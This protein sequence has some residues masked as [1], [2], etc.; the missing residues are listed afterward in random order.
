M[1]SKV[2]PVTI[3]RHRPWQFLPLVAFLVFSPPAEAN[4]VFR[5]FL[6]F[7]TPPAP[8]SDVTPEKTELAP[9]VRPAE[10]AAAGV[11]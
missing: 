3:H 10:S 1:I 8:A 6:P 2:I 7:L 5:Q 4:S 11:K 9:P